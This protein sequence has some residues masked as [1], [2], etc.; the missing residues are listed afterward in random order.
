MTTATR[1]TYYMAI[2]FGSSHISVTIGAPTGDPLATIKEPIEYFKPEGAPQKALEFDPAKTLKLVITT[3]QRAIG[4]SN[5]T[6]AEIS[7]IGVT[8]QRQGL[9]LLNLEGLAIYGGPDRDLRAVAEGKDID[10]NALVDV[11]ELTGHGPGMRTA[12]AR[13]KWFAANSPEIYDRTR[14]MCGIADWLI[15][16]LTGELM[17]E[18]TLAVE[19]GLG[20]VASG[21]P[22]RAFQRPHR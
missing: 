13:L 20:L 11:W 6:P 19:A 22:A 18:E 21:E 12:W 8:S 7:G 1:S 5:L 16:E 15:L 14:T 4:A 17:M 10:A 3:A 9:V 2:N